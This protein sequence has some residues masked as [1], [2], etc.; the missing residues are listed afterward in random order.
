MS[1]QI[2]KMSIDCMMVGYY[3]NGTTLTEIYETSIKI[4]KGDVEYSRIVSVSYTNNQSVQERADFRIGKAYRCPLIWDGYDI[5]WGH[6]SLK[7]K[8]SHN[9]YVINPN[10]RMPYFTKNADVI[11]CLGFYLDC[12]E[13]PIV[14][15]IK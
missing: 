8:R 14:T 12:P 10:N 15:K 13:S 6:P 5:T 9:A 2:R 1:S 7:P 11:K 4:K 3:I